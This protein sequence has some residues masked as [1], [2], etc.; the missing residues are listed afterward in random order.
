M[1]NGYDL[2]DIKSCC[3]EVSDVFRHSNAKEVFETLLRERFGVRGIELNVTLI[4]NPAC[5]R[6]TVNSKPGCVIPYLGIAA[7]GF[8]DASVIDSGCTFFRRMSHKTK[9]VGSVEMSG[10]IVLKL[11]YADFGKNYAELF[12]YEYSVDQGWIFAD[13]FGNT[14]FD[15]YDEIPT[16]IKSFIKEMA[17]PL[18]TDRIRLKNPKWRRNALHSPLDWEIGFLDDFEVEK[19]F[20]IEEIKQDCYGWCGGF[21]SYIPGQNAQLTFHYFADDVPYLVRTIIDDSMQAELNK[22]CKKEYEAFVS[23]KY[24]F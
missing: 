22:I 21:L 19:A 4:N 18:E 9:K 7:H 6:I 24:S 16:P 3:T 14:I 1:D 20:D 11:S 12:R 5:V 8:S 2:I 15:A 13:A 17:Y 23:A 10:A